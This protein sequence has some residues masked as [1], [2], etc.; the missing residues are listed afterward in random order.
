GR[1]RPL[2][3]AAGAEDRDARAGR[4]GG[5]S[6]SPLNTLRVA[7]RAILRNKLRSFLTT[8]GIV[9]GVGAVIA[10]MAIGA[11]AK[12]QVEQAFAAMGTN[13]LI[14]L[15]G[16]TSSSGVH[17][18][19]GSMPTLTWDDLAAIRTEVATVKRAAP[20]LR[21]SLPVVSEDQN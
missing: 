1:T 4:S 14:V 5:R 16:S 10:M 18:G 6:V 17:G 9:I 3:H 2:R 19:F 12:A 20:S 21:A 13:V 15:P 8:L 11:G 7:S